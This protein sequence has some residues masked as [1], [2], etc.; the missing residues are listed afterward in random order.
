MLVCNTVCTLIINIAL[1]LQ[2]GYCLCQH[3]EIILQAYVYNRFVFLASCPG[4]GQ[5]R[6]TDNLKGAP[7]DW[8]ILV[9]DTDAVR[10]VSC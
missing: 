7:V 10:M 2:T 4:I 8:A 5:G 3:Q 6:V 9:K 1:L